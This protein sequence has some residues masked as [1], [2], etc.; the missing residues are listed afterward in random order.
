MADFLTSEW[1]AVINA[2]LASQEL[3]ATDSWRVVLSWTD[4]P[5]QLPHAITL[6]A[7]NGRISVEH[8][9]HLAADAVVV[10]SFADAKALSTGKLDT[11]VALR[12]GRLKLRGDSSAIVAMANAIRA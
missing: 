11:S 5:A 4:G 9:D 12:E 8:G 6:S 10:L 2:S 7:I 3:A 1:F